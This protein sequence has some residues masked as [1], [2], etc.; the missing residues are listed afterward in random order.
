MS[1]P[2]PRERDCSVRRRLILTA[3]AGACLQALPASRLSAA[4]GIS[5]EQFIAQANPAAARLVADQSAA[6]QDRYLHTLASIATLLADAPLPAKWNDSAQGRARGDYTIG[7]HP[8]G[9]PFRVLH[10]RLKPNAVCRPHAHTYGNVVSLGLSGVARVRNYEVVGEPDY[11]QTREFLVRETVDQQLRK[12][13]VNLLSLKRNYIHA[14]EAGPEGARGLDITTP[15][16]PK[17]DHGTPYLAIAAEAVDEE[18]RAF[19]ARWEFD[20]A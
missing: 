17:P 11:G 9:E 7:F 16:Q 12:G 20:E 14:F 6:G 5:L 10:W 1:Y 15:L 4:T 18:R 3:V 8:G 2:S 13:D 19:R